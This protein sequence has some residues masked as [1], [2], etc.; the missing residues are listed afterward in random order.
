M[1]IKLVAIMV[2]LGL[3]S[4]TNHNPDVGTVLDSH[5]GVAV[6][7]N[8]YFTNNSGRNVAKDGYNLG[9]KWQC[10]EF[11][12]RYYYL[13]YGLKMSD[14]FGNAKDFFDDTLAD[15]EFNVARGM[16][17]FRNTRRNPPM[18]N[19]L[20]IYGSSD[21]NPYGHMGI[22]TSIVDG[23]IDMIQQ[24][25]GIKTRQELILAEFQG[26]YTIADF[27]VL[28]WLRPLNY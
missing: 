21:S 25:M 17:Q 12:K 15:K 10:V 19:D 4:F 3:L 2:I 27:D 9:L 6:Y 18:V 16:M 23:K 24:N 28:G 1:K 14:S 11:A 8:G 7:Y 26:I 5:N 13:K 20:I 22:I